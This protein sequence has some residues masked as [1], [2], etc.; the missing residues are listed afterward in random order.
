[1]TVLNAFPQNV[2]W[3]IHIL[4][5]TE[6]RT[7]PLY[8]SFFFPARSLS[9][10][11]F[12]CHAFFSLVGIV[13]RICVTLNYPTIVLA[14]PM[15]LSNNKQSALFFFSHPCSPFASPSCYRFNST[16]RPAP[17]LCLLGR[18]NFFFHF[19]L[20]KARRVLSLSSYLLSVCG[21]LEKEGNLKG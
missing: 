5:I 10:V 18:C 16:V 19:I 7:P 13:A 1:M 12:S 3:C 17:R 15:Q 21:D 14:L 2:P 20:E 4:P 11:S 6:D 8:V 9:S